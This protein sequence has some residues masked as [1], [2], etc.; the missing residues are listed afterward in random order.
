MRLKNFFFIALSLFINLSSHAQDNNIT[1]KKYFVGSTL[2]MIANLVDDPE[3]SYGYG[4]RDSLGALVINI[5]LLWSII[6]F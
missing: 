1:D 2:F 3:H 5:L 4:A 6:R